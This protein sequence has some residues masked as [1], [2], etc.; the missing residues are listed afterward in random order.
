MSVRKSGS[1]VKKARTQRKG[2]HKRKYHPK[3]TIPA[4]KTIKASEEE[5]LRTTS[6]IFSERVTRISTGIR[7]VFPKE[8]YL[9]PCEEWG[10]REI[11]FTKKDDPEAVE[12]DL[13]K[14]LPKDHWILYNMQIISFGRQ[15]CFARNPKC[16]RCPLQ[17]Y[18]GESQAKESK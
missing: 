2:T 4:E 6:A 3:K 1:A 9:I 5:I 18:C 14:V 13:M 11:G 10:S 17:T 15:I 12:Y 16:D 7:E 8:G